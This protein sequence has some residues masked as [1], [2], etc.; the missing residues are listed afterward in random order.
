M[1]K[2]KILSTRVLPENTEEFL[3]F[4]LGNT[5]K[6]AEQTY[7]N[8]KKLLNNM[9]GSYAR[10]SGLLKEDLFGEALIGLARAMRDYDK[11]KNDNIF[12]YASY[13]IRSVLN[14]YCYKNRSI[15]SIPN[16]VAIAYGYIN[17]IRNIL[18]KYPGTEDKI[19]EFLLDNKIPDY[20]EL[21]KKE[22]EICETVLKHLAILAINSKVN[23]AD[24]IERAEYVPLNVTFEENYLS[25][26][27]C[28][29]RDVK[30]IQLT[31]LISSL[32]NKMTEKEIAIADGILM[33]KTYDEIGAEQTPHRSA[34][35]VRKQLD[36]IRKKVMED[37]V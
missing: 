2:L 11:T 30:Q 4:F 32:K 12:V 31:A 22:R 7:I 14:E 33:G 27:D 23:Y 3:P 24:L 6:E 19:K 28:E 25:V 15:V 34:A 5:E 29:E 17:R 35:W 37:K 10:S 9:S 26:E 13:R 18:L 16:Y 20:F 21:P 8:F 1:N 36:N